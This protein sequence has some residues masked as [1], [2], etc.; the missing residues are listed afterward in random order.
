MYVYVLGY[1]HSTYMG[2]LYV[3]VLEYIE[4]VYVERQGSF[5]WTG[6][7]PGH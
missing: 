3:S 5:C 7:F 6:V 1:E 2:R 4:V